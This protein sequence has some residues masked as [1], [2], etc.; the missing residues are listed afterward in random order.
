MV[1]EKWQGREWTKFLS[2]HFFFFF[3]ALPMDFP[4]SSV[5]WFGTEQVNS[6]K[7]NGESVWMRKIDLT[8]LTICV[9][10]YKEETE[11]GMKSRSLLEWLWTYHWECGVW[12]CV[13]IKT[14]DMKTLETVYRTVFLKLKLYT[15]QVFKWA[16][17]LTWQRLL[18]CK[19]RLLLLYIVLDIDLFILLCLYF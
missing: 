5:C 9:W 11:Q 19:K 2:F 7:R 14:F 4:F 18:N 16:F 13:L 6:K 8:I 1:V 10:S 3:L 12:V 15:W 17:F